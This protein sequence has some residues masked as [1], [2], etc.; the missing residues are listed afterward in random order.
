MPLFRLCSYRMLRKNALMM[1]LQRGVR[2][3]CKALG[4]KPATESNVDH[5]RRILQAQHTAHADAAHDSELQLQRTLLEA[6]AQRSDGREERRETVS[7]HEQSIGGAS[8]SVKVSPQDARC[9]YVCVCRVG[10]WWWGGAVGVVEG[11]M[12]G[13]GWRVRFGHP[14][15]LG[16][17]RS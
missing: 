1:A 2:L 14:G 12:E 9:V 13:I 4:G 17:A 15:M 5:A 3:I 6:M 8:A 7:L 11:G 10:R 16:P